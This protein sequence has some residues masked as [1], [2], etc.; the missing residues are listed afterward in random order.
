[1][2]IAPEILDTADD[3]GREAAAEIADAIAEAA[4]HGRTFVL[5]CPSGRSPIATYAHLAALVAERD[6][7]L[8]RVVVALM[9]EYVE[10]AEGGFRAIDPDLPHSCVGFGRREILGLLNAAATPEHRIPEENLWYPDAAA[11]A[12][13]YDRALAEAG[14]IDVF[15]LASGAS[16]GHVALNPVGAGADTVTRVVPLGEDT[17]RDNLGT[18]PTLRSLDEAPRF[19]VTVGIATIRELSRRALMVV[20]GEHKRETVQRL[21]AADAYEP[22]WPATVLSECSDARFLVDRS[23]AGLLQTTR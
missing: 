3:V 22:D 19:G 6:L 5:G 2:R 20:T 11:P 13:Q 15:L 1:M 17:R 18:F 16:D 21:A 23:A 12:G 14:G 7:D 4:A 9:D 10:E 8:S